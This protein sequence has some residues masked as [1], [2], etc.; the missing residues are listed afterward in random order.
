VIPLQGV[1][2]GSY[3]ALILFFI[4]FYGLMARKN[5]IK[6]IISFGIIQAAIILYFL[7]INWTVDANPPIG[8]L[9]Q[10]S[11]PL[12]QA[13][14]ITAV[15]IGISSTAVG[16]TMFISLYHHY[17]TTNWEKI[18]AKRKEEEQ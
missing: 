8:M 3:V 14:M 15:V 1:L 13:L 17:G 7:N 16:L 9:S 6:T 5:I 10:M 2:N 11:D 4:G 12:P 18:I